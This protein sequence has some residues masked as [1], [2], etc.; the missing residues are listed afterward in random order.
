MVSSTPFIK[1]VKLS[2]QG[3]SV[4][5]ISCNISA[6][7]PVYPNICNQPT[8]QLRCVETREEGMFAAH[9]RQ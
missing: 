4:I 6:D 9:V 2:Y 7:V 5:E 1:Q 8:S 3:K